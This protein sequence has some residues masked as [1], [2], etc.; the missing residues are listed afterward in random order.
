MN[1]KELLQV[2]SQEDFPSRMEAFCS[3]KQQLPL[4]VFYNSFV[5]DNYNPR[6]TVTDV[7]TQVFGRPGLMK[8][9][10]YDE[11]LFKE[12]DDQ[13]AYLKALPQQL[14]QIISSIYY[15]GYD[16]VML[17]AERLVQSSGKHVVVMVPEKNEIIDES[18]GA[19]N[20]YYNDIATDT[21]L[22]WR[23]RAEVWQ[24]DRP[25]C[26]GQTRQVYLACLKASML[27]M[28]KTWLE[29]GR[30]EDILKAVDDRKW[31]NETYRQYVCSRN[32]VPYLLKHATFDERLL[33]DEMETENGKVIRIKV[34]NMENARCIE[35]QC[36]NDPWRRIPKELELTL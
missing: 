23:G 17:F 14:I 12:M 2:I 18:F 1:N 5:T 28:L 27:D 30:K 9:I 4:A 7:S 32:N 35:Y 13:I 34:E 15:D 6:K 29:E 33:V 20:I 8:K 19:R 36:L 25:S 22:T 21:L 3:E 16:H 24:A 26:Y 31:L 11:R 10:T